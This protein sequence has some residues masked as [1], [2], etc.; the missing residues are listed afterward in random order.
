M[1]SEAERRDV[2]KIGNKNKRGIFNFTLT[3][4]VLPLVLTTENSIE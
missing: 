4:L 2:E 3:P 1:V